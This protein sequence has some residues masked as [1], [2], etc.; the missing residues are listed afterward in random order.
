MGANNVDHPVRGQ[1][2]NSE[3]DKEGNDVLSLRGNPKGPFVK[4]GFP[5]WD[6]E[7]CRAKC[8]T[9]EETEGGT[10]CYAC[11]SQGKRH[12][13]PPHRA[14]KDGEIHGAWQ[15]KGL[16]AKQQSENH[17]IDGDADAQ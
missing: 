8:S 10:H 3:N 5:L 9:D 6:C 14:T 2:D 13:H 4:A 17:W 1:R 15:R 7:E 16:D 11:T 12:G